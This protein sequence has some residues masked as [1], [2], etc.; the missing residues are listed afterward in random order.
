MN[1]YK[2]ERMEEALGRL[3][4]LVYKMQVQFENADEE[5]WMWQKA[6]LF[7]LFG[8]VLLVCV[9]LGLL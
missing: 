4:D 7:S 8:N 6:F 2:V 5:A 1:E 3:Q 9:I